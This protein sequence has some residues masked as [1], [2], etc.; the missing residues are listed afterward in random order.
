MVALTRKEYENAGT[1]NTKSPLPNSFKNTLNQKNF[2]E[3]SP[4]KEN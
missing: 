1:R 4:S 2:N 3:S